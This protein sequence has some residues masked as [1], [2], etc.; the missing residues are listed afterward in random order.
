MNSR[1]GGHSPSGALG[2]PRTSTV[3]GFEPPRRVLDVS[4]RF[5][6]LRVYSRRGQHLLFKRGKKTFRLAHRLPPSDILLL[7]SLTSHSVFPADREAQPPESCQMFG[8]PGLG[9]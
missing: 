2:G 7:L 4:G 1:F 8:W 6:Q 9:L 3:E 5:S